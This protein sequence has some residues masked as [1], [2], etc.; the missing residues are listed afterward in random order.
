MPGDKRR[1][2]TT[3]EKASNRRLLEMAAKMDRVEFLE[4]FLSV[5]VDLEA[6]GVS[7]DE[8]TLS[9]RRICDKLGIDLNWVLN[10]QRGRNGS[11]PVVKV[12]GWPQRSG[13][14]LP[15]ETQA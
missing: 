3:L 8:I 13:A 4:L 11:R 5:T 6:E 15:Y 14:A 12:S 2:F 9:C 1:S 7:R 10:C